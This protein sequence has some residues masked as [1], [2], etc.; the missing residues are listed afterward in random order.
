MK[1]FTPKT[2]EPTDLFEE[3]ILSLKSDLESL[4]YFENI[5][6]YAAKYFSNNPVLAENQ[7]K[8]KSLMATQFVFIDENNSSNCPLSGKF[9]ETSKEHAEKISND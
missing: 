3:N 8:I 2:T 9:C 7:D 6:D 5:E 4:E 1:K